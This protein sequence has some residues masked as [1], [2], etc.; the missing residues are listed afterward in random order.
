M[1]SP[2][3]TPT[4]EDAAAKYFYL[5]VSFLRKIITNATRANSSTQDGIDVGGSDLSH[6]C[7]LIRLLKLIRGF[8]L[9]DAILW[10]YFNW[11]EIF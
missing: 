9:R 8:L 5:F 11:V 6:I 3:K 10:G 7:K 2:A 1:L 4:E